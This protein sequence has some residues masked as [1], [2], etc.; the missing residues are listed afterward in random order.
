MEHIGDSVQ[1]R[2][3]PNSIKPKRRGRKLEVALKQ[4]A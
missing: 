1:Q 3:R 4:K 2:S